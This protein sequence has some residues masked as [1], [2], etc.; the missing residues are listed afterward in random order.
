MDDIT[1][2]SWARKRAW[3]RRYGK[4]M[5]IGALLVVALGPS[6]VKGVA[7]SRGPVQR[8]YAA[9]SPEG[10]SA[11]LKWNDLHRGQWPAKGTPRVVP[12]IG[13]LAGKTVHL[14]G[15]MLPLHQAQEASEFFLAASP[16]GCYF[17]SPPGVADVVMATTVGRKKMSITDQPVEAF[18]TL[19]LAAG[20]QDQALYMIDDATFVIKRSIIDTNSP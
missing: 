1:Q 11:A 9:R 4:L 16:G 20:S 3:G 12:A 10:T 8:G 7:K 2:E 17:C 6:L 19:R 18:G 14:K 15:F 5:A 13:D